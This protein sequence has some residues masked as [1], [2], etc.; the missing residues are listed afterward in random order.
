M[1]IL[2]GKREDC[3]RGGEARECGHGHASHCTCALLQ[4]F[5]LFSLLVVMYGVD[6]HGFFQQK[7]RRF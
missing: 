3:E 5:E 4:S 1:S 2:Q 7:M 6:C